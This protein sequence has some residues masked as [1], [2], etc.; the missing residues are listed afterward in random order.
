MGSVVQYSV[1]RVTGDTVT[2]ASVRVLVGEVLSQ[3]GV[4]T[5]PSS[6]VKSS[7]T[8]WSLPT[9]RP[10]CS[11]MKRCSGA[12]NFATIT[13][14]NDPPAANADAFS[15]P[16]DT[17]LTVAN[18]LANDPD[19]DS[20]PGRPRSIV[21]GGPSHGTVALNADGT[22][23]YTP[24]ADYYGSDSFT[25]KA[26]DGLWSPTTV[27]LSVDSPVTTV[28]ITVT[29]VNDPPVAADDS[30]TTAEDTMLV[31]PASD[32][33]TNDTAGPANEN[34]QH[35]TVVS[36]A[37]TETTH[38]LISLV[39]GSVRYQ[40]ADNYNGP[41]SFTYTVWDDGT[42]NGASD[43]R[44][45]VASVNVTVTEVNDQPVPVDDQKNTQRN[46]SLVFPSSDL[47]ANDSAGPAN[48]GSQ[49]LTVTAVAATT[50]THGE[51]SLENGVIT[52]VPAEG[53]AGS[54]A[55]DYTVE[56]DGTTNG[57]PDHKSAVGHVTV[58]VSGLSAIVTTSTKALVVDIATNTVTTSLV[59]GT[60][61]IGATV[62]PDGRRGIVADFN[63]VG[64]LRLI[65]LTTDPP[66]LGPLVLCRSST[67]VPG[68]HGR[69][70]R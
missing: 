10:R 65:E 46:T 1:Y 54:A 48:E 20:Y 3:P 57:A 63:G 61:L 28:L 19:V 44:S 15:T 9:L 50:A 5:T 67:S 42:T 8:A 27:P 24:V 38:G 14:V 13:A 70:S 37:A 22:F 60:N 49:L 55:F 4:A 51:V 7:R 26:N 6:M 34:G 35:L 32:L 45:V 11:T 40:P 52:Y 39:E 59:A 29:E 18:V 56:D 43:P 31:F 64:T 66:S 47:T 16:E 21:V 33:L 12:S 41:A 69:D 17:P 68:E 36:V 25:Y 2:P 62:T 23:V 30:K 58:T 53:F